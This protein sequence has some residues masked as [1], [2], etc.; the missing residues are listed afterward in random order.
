MFY[1]VGTPPANTWSHVD[2]MVLTGALILVLDRW[3]ESLHRLG[4]HFWTFTKQAAIAFF[5]A[6]QKARS[7]ESIS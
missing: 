5:A 1:F 6:V 3:F 2:E 7:F 4:R